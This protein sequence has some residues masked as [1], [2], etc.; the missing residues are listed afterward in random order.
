MELKY[1]GKETYL[2]LLPRSSLARVMGICGEI[3]SGDDDFQRRKQIN[4]VS[5]AG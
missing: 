2:G 3:A 5:A 1:V 4:S